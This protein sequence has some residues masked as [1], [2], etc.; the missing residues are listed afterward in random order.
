MDECNILPLDLD[1]DQESFSLLMEELTG[2]VV[3]TDISQFTGS[4]C[5][6]FKVVVHQEV[7]GIGT[8]IFHPTPMYGW[9]A[10]LED[11]IVT[12]DYRGKGYGKC[13][14][15]HLLETVRDF[16]PKVKKVFVNSNPKREVAT[17]LYTSFGFKAYKMNVFVL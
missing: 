1:N 17:A 14:M 4:N 9:V 16:Q 2:K 11:I 3:T 7:I 8:V 6:I 5:H 13:L 15:S 12:S 10:R